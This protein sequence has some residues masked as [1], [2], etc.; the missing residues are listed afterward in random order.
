[1][2]LS[3]HLADDPDAEGPC[4]RP[5]IAAD[6]SN[7]LSAYVCASRVF[8]GVSLLRG[9]N[10]VV[11]LEGYIRVP[12]EELDAVK[13]HLGEHINNTLNEDG[14]L[15]FVVKQDDSDQC[16]FHVFEKFIDSDAFDAHQVRTKASDWGIITKNVERV[17]E[18]RFEE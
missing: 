12:F 18:Q 1:M 17:Y 14:C 4:A 16:V 2:F 8:Y 13:T 3:L 15:E 5:V 10:V 6:H 11:I 7:L 9:N